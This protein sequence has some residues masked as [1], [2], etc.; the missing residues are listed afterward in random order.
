AARALRSAGRKKSK[1]KS[2]NRGLMVVLQGAGILFLLLF[3]AAGIAFAL[4]P[5][6]AN[7]LYPQSEHPMKKK[8]TYDAAWARL[9]G[10]DGPVREFIRRYPDDPRIDQVREWA[11]TIQTHDLLKRLETNARKPKV[12]RPYLFNLDKNYEAQVFMALRFEEFGDIW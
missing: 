4:R 7:S 10:S 1:K 11:E 5:P 9:N 3:L 2:S 6:S 12:L 8:E